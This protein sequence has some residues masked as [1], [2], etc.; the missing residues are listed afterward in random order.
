MDDEMEDDDGIL[1]RLFEIDYAGGVVA[2]KKGRDVMG[3]GGYQVRKK[4]VGGRAVGFTGGVH[5]HTSHV[6]S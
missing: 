5:I 2:G 3:I 1:P 6:N 4:R